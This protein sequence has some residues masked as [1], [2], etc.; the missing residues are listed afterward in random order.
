MVNLN[1][2][3]HG[4]RAEPDKYIIFQGSVYDEDSALNKVIKPPGSVAISGDPDLPRD[5]VFEQLS[6]ATD[7]TGTLTISDGARETVITIN[8]EGAISW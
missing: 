5:I 2:S 6:G 8:E 1:E 4:I 7:D 3:P